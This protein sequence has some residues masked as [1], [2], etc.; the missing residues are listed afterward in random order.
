MAE[1]SAM[2]NNIASSH[3]AP[4]ALR[5]SWDCRSSAE[6]GGSPQKE[7]KLSYPLGL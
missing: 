3:G 2:F 1:V 7:T 5:R 4:E 6:G